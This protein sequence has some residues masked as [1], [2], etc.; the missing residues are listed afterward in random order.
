[1]ARNGHK[2]SF[3]G[4]IL[5]GARP[6]YVEPTYDEELE[7]THEVLA[8]DLAETLDANRGAR[9][10][11]VFTPSYYGTSGDVKALA[12]ACH[13]RGIPLVTDDAWGLDADRPS[14]PAAR[15]ARAGLGPG[16][17]LGA[18]DAVG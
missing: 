10:A 9:A 8:D 7:L 3:T 2:S 18:Q 15:R 17:R 14:R 16:D 6:V 12:R 13:N 1:M 4:L 5:A 11:M